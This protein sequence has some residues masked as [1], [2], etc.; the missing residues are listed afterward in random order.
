VKSDRVY[1]DKHKTAVTALAKRRTSLCT[2]W[3]Q[4]ATASRPES[5]RRHT[6]RRS[7]RASSLR[8]DSFPLS[9]KLIPPNVFATLYPF[10]I[11][12]QLRFSF[13]SN[14]FANFFHFPLFEASL[15][16][17]LTLAIQVLATS[18]SESANFIE[19]PADSELLD[20]FPEYNAEWKYVPTFDLHPS[21]T[22]FPMVLKKETPQI[23]EKRK[24]K[25]EQQYEEP[26]TS[27]EEL[28]EE[29]EL[30]LYRAT[31]RRRLSKPNGASSL[32]SPS[33]PSPAIGKR[34]SISSL[35]S[36]SPS[37]VP[38]GRGRPRKVSNKNPE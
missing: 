36:P 3:R 30:D 12:N 22:H 31:K 37:P 16:F 19:N 28:M 24:C 15:V 32:S 25:S 10:K 23:L 29:E 4:E 9:R 18:N 11:L 38:R 27:D 2:D 21:I 20:W 1:S 8:R 14:A 6:A 34:K 33:A 35:S 5:S 13:F 17:F 7:W 26:D